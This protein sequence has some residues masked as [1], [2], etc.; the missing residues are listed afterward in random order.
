MFVLL[1]LGN[2]ITF[3]P[4]VNIRSPEVFPFGYSWRSELTNGIVSQPIKARLKA[5]P[6]PSPQSL[7]CNNCQV[8]SIATVLH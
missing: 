6:T 5:T 2:Q 4:T 7:A 3:N 1:G 8:S